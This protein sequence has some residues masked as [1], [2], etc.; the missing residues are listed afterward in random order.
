MT[1]INNNVSSYLHEALNNILNPTDMSSPSRCHTLVWLVRW[2]S[3][4]R[5]NYYSHGAALISWG[6]FVGFYYVPVPSL[7]EPP[8]M[9]E[10]HGRP[11]VRS[12]W[13]NKCY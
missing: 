1:Q 4:E 3:V 5:D 6:A 10:D 2:K 13:V 11:I 7:A 12:H 8:G 9:V